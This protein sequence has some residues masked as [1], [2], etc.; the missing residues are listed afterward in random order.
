MAGHSHAKNVMHRK[1]AQNSKKAKIY[2]KI[3][4]AITLAIK[5]GGSIDPDSNPKLRLALRQ[6]QVAGVPKE[7]IK[8]SI[9]KSAQADNEEEILYEGYAP[10]GIAVLVETITDNKVRTASEIRSIFSKYG[11]AMAEPNSV[12]FMFD[13]VAQ[14]ECEV[15]EDQFEAFFEY[16]V[17]G[18][19]TDVIENMAIFAPENYHSAQE[20][21]ETKFPVVNSEFCYIPQNLIEN[22]KTEGFQKLIDVLEDNENV[23]NCWHNLKI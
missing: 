4:R 15:P 14:I 22:E 2:T 12:A 3:S 6:A 10:G 16:A 18:N 8:R 7:V 23:Q 13:K 1:A 5:A 9:D 19:A 21:L 20:Y 11:G 17:E